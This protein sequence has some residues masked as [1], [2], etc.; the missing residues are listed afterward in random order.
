[1]GRSDGRSL[2]ELGYGGD[3][4]FRVLVGETLDLSRDETSAPCLINDMASTKGRL[5]DADV[6]KRLGAGDEVEEWVDRRLF[7]GLEDFGIS[8]GP[9]ALSPGDLL[10]PALRSM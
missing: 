5:P 2:E 4:L 8:L 6:D 7:S 10:I 3:V 9:R 1:M